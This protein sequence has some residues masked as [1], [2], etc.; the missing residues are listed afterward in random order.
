MR[1]VARVTQVWQG[2]VEWALGEGS[3]DKL[4]LLW[5]LGQTTP[6]SGPQFPRLWSAGLDEPGAS[7]PQRRPSRRLSQAV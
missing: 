4:H 1:Q 6:T 3:G 7:R 5:G 2:A